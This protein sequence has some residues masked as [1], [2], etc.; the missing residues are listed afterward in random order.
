MH[1]SVS[2]VVIFTLMHINAVA[3]MISG[4]FKKLKYA[5]FRLMPKAFPFLF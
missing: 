2:L 3:I 1:H 4:L 5:Y